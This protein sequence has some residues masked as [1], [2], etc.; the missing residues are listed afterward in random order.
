MQAK[1]VRQNSW[2]TNGKYVVVNIINSSIGL[3]GQTIR[4]LDTSA[5][6]VIADKDA[7]SAAGNVATVNSLLRMGTTPETPKQT[8]TSGIC[9]AEGYELLPDL[10]LQTEDTTICSGRRRRV[11]DIKV[12]V[13]CFASHVRVVAANQPERVADVLGYYDKH[14]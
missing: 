12:W 2:G 9:L 8:R 10:W 5:L 13:Q 14:H 11:M 1:H 6:P 4:Q 3:D 7:R